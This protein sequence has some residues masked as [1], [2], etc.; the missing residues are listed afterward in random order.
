M[1]EMISSRPH[2]AGGP[3]GTDVEPARVKV[4]QA[5]R[6]ELLEAGFR[7]RDTGDG[8]AWNRRDG[9]G[10]HVM[11]SANGALSGDPDR[12]E[13]TAGRY[14]DKGGF[15]EVTGLTLQAALDAVAI[16]PRPVRVDGSL[17]EAIY[18]SLEEAMS[19]FA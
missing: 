8:M 2:G 4:P 13:W 1:E 15:I 14:G 5:L 12:G 10:T 7:P 19:D 18:P 6:D 17:A 16:L 9:D 11:I 3:Y